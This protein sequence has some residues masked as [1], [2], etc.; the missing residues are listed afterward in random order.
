MLISKSKTS[1][2]KKRVMAF[3]VA[4]LL[5]LISSHAYGATCEQLLQR[6]VKVSV[7]SRDGQM[8]LM[9]SISPKLLGLLN[10]FE[11][12]KNKF[13]CGIASG[14]I[15][16]NAHYVKDPAHP[17]PHDYS[18]LAYAADHLPAEFIPVFARF[19]QINFLNGE[20]ARV[21]DLA[22]IYGKSLDGSVNFGSSGLQLRELARIIE[23]HGPS[24]ETQIVDSDSESHY[25]RQKL[26][27]AVKD[28][29][30]YVIVNFDRK[31]LGQKGAGHISPLGA[32][33]AET[34]SVLVVD[35]NPT[36]AEWTWV[37]VSTLIKAMAT[38]DQVENRGFLVVRKPSR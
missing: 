5:A 33:D 10:Q 17:T 16:L 1:L 31:V 3:S 26:L 11:P 24:V 38:R 18:Q 22:T 19:T 32:Y 9:R 14:V 7:S 29:S 6:E 25:Y 37:D 34:D 36:D 20:S 23:G 13:Y 35:V 4:L 12:Q 28:D 8:R 21:K 30:S 27:A 15:V 2:F